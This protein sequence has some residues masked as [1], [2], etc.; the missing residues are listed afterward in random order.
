MMFLSPGLGPLP[1]ALLWQRHRTRGVRDQLQSLQL[2]A[3]DGV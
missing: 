1:S 3:A 2:R